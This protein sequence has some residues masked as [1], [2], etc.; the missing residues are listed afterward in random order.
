MSTLQIG[1][2]VALALAV[3]AVGAAGTSCATFTDPTVCFDMKPC[4][5]CNISGSCYD[6]VKQTCCNNRICDAKSERCCKNFPVFMPQGTCC[7]EGHRCCSGV[8]PTCCPSNSTCCRVPGGNMVCC[9]APFKCI[10]FCCKE[11]VVCKED[12]KECC[13]GMCVPKIGCVP[14]PMSRDLHLP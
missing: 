12:G 13:K 4:A 5:W 1:V 7:S 9:Q 10:Y 11:T 3:F 8:I 6:S 2:A 14:P